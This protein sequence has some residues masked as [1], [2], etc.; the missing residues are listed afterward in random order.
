MGQKKYMATIGMLGWMRGWNGKVFCDES[1]LD[2]PRHWRNPRKIFVCSMSDLFH[3]KV[4]FEFIDG[5]WWTM[6]V[7]R[8]HTFQVLT[9]RPER[10]LEYWQHRLRKGFTDGNREN[11]WAGVSVCTPDE[12]DKIDILRQIPA[13]VKFVSFEPLLADMGLLNLEGINWVII[14]AESIGSHPGR[15][16]E[17]DWVKS[18]AIQCV[19]AG[20]KIFIKQIHLNGKLLKY[21][22]D[23]DKF[24]KWAQRQEYPNEP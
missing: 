20:V 5:V 19:A 2:K 16:C 10:Y 1:A 12:K 23:I 15:K 24:P 7:S 9:K 6:S 18:I 3:P 17:L 22:K 11:I 8:Q 21:P 13:A 4:P 14:G